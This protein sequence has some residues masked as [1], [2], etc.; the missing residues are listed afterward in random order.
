MAIF[1]SSTADEGS[2]MH[3]EKLP[4]YIRK[5]CWNDMIFCIQYGDIY[6]VLCG[7]NINRTESSKGI[8]NNL[9]S[10]KINCHIQ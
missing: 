9:M 8:I 6:K 10:V 7:Y 3:S 1:P 2:W 4:E 5:M